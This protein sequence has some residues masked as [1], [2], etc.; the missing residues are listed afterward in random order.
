[1]ERSDPAWH[2]RGRAAGPVLWT[3]MTASGGGR[4]RSSARS[5]IRLR[6][7]RSYLFFTT[8]TGV[9]REAAAALVSIGAPAMDAVVSALVDP[10]D[11][12]RKRA[13][14][15]LTEIRG[16]TGGRSSPKSPQ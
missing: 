10:D 9:R 6:S 16:C 4:P 5:V 1:M 12:V 11:D 3:A 2:G 15:V 14:D 8:S 13:A 7:R